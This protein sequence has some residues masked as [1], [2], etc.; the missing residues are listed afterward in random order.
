[1]EGSVRERKTKRLTLFGQAA[2]D[3][4]AA[5][6]AAAEDERED[7]GAEG[8]E[9]LEPAEALERVRGAVA[10]SVHRHDTGSS[11]EASGHQDGRAAVL[12]EAAATPPAG[13][14]FAYHELC[15][16]KGWDPVDPRQGLP[17]K[18]ECQDDGLLQH[19]FGATDEHSFLAV[20]DGH[21]RDGKKAANFCVRALEPDPVYHPR[22]AS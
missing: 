5:L 15:V 1:M 6:A 4:G 20:F 11:T 17:L 12:L 2:Q 21:G 16:S 3:L 8:A 9:A 18:T 19:S 13:A 10:G 7:V 14:P 22:A